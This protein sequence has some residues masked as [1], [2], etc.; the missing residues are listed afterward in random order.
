MRHL[1]R[2]SSFFLA[3]SVSLAGTAWAGEPLPS[4]NDGP[5]KRAILDF[6]KKVTTPG[7]PD[8]VPVPE[9]I[10]T[11]DNDGTLWVEQPF[12]TQL[13]FALDRVKALAPEHPEWKEKEPFK[14]VL[15]GDLKGVLA[16][17]DHAL[18]EI[19]MV[20]H[21]G[22][23]PEEFGKV[24]QDWIAT[25]KH[26]R[27]GKPYTQCVYQP[28][29]ELLSYL[30]ENGFKTY[31]VSGG[32]V[33]FMRAFAEKVYG[34]PPEQTIG[35]TIKT[36]WEMRDGKGV[37]VR[38]PGVDYVD[39]KAGKPLAIERIIGRRPIASFGNSDGDLEMLQWTAAGDGARLC[40]LVHHDDG[41]R[42]YA[43]DRESK[44]G[45]LDKALDA[46]KAAGW[47]IVS[48]KN[49]WNRIFAFEGE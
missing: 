48:M 3:L 37:I 32:G 42:E 30:R 9:R 1:L 4:W 17:G 21:A 27:F 2:F 15:A 10:A 35:S 18:A 33:E 23:T 38:E 24:V 43:Y 39:D 45:H 8:F 22:M 36:K 25:A 7:S 49:D 46:G 28:M 29:L 41:K 11:F 34:V 31:I 13:A 20:T 47:T 26:P 44:I 40:L 14:S 12:Y 16:G 5:S 19:V 6:V